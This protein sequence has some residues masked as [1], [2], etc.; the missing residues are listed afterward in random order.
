MP[1]KLTAGQRKKS[2]KNVKRQASSL[3]VWFNEQTGQIWESVVVHNGKVSRR[4]N[5]PEAATLEL[6]HE[7]LTDAL[8]SGV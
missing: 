1:K 6:A 3:K 2:H 8:K 5:G 4:I 7:L